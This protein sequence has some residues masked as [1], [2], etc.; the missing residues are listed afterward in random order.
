VIVTS[1]VGERGQ[2]FP[3]SRRIVALCNEISRESLLDSAVPG[4]VYYGIHHGAI[5][6]VG[7]DHG[8]FV[9]FYL[10]GKLA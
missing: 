3:V 1:T 7:I 8:C 2:S 4:C 9:F 10:P 6:R 5:L